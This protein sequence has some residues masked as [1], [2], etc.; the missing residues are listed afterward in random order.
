MKNKY[1][2]VVDKKYLHRDILKIFPSLKARTVISWSERGLVKADL[3]E[4]SGRGSS[5]VFSYSNLIEIGI[6][7]ELLHTG[8][9]FATIK[10]ITN[11]PAVRDMINSKTFD[12]VILFQRQLSRALSPVDKAAP[13]MDL[14][15]TAN[16]VDFFTG[17]RKALSNSTSLIIVNV[18]NIKN[19]INMRVNMLTNQDE[20]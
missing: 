19:Y 17:S 18:E 15:G 13:W 3:G 16:A 10:L 7:S 14:C 8:I 1:Q 9:P 4:A 20:L 6:L 12:K 11:S 2:Y 5:R